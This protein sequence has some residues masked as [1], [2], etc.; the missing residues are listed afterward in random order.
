VNIEMAAKTT[1][2]KVFETWKKKNDGTDEQIMAQLRATPTQYREL[3]GEVLTP[4]TS[5]TAGDHSGARPGPYLT[6]QAIDSIANR[7]GI[8]AAG[9]TSI[10]KS[11]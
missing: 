11:L 8:S 5:T 1:I 9:L 10:I 4:G 6:K 2:G 3:L 7:R